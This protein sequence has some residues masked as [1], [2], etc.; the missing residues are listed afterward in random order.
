MGY[1]FNQTYECSDCG[2][3]F[4]GLS[5]FQE[6]G[7]RLED[8]HHIAPKICKKCGNMVNVVTVGFDKDNAVC[9]NCGSELELM[10]EDIIYECPQCHKKTLKCVNTDSVY[11]SGNIYIY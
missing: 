8:E 5:G 10:K 11:S 6:H 3:V 4:N 9:Q 7:D 2:Y 1:T